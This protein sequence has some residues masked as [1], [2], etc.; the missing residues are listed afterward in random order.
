MSRIEAHRNAVEKTHGGEAIFV[1][2]IPVHVELE[3]KTAWEGPVSLFAIKGHP[4][5]ISCYAWSIPLGNERAEKFY[6]VLHTQEVYCAAK[7]VRDSF[8]PLARS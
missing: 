2:S 8:L 4:S 1:Y 3:G 7:A 6:A 5:S